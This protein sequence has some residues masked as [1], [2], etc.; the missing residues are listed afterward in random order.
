VTSEETENVV[1]VGAVH[2]DLVEEGVGSAIGLGEFFN[3][4][5]I[6]GLLVHE[7]VAWEGKDLE[8]FVT[9]C[10]VELCHPL[11]VTG[12]QSSEASNICDKSY[13]LSSCVDTDFRKRQLININSR[14]FVKS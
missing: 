8:T 7:L 10:S 13:F 11:V 5:V 14:N 4:G 6:I 3:P 9:I 2:I 12:G 1:S